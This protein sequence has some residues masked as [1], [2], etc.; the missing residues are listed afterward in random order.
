MNARLP[1]A[2]IELER[3]R[4]RQ[5]EESDANALFAIHS[6]LE[7]ARY[8]SKPAMTDRAQAEELVKR[9]RAG[10]EDG[11]SLQLGIERKE[12]GVLI[13]YCLLFHFDEENRRA[14]IGYSLGRPY[15]GRGY[16]HEALLALLE[17]AFGAL[18]LN[19]LEAD[20]DPRNAPSARSL[21]RL[22]FKKEGYLR[23]RWIVN[24]E[25]SD[26]ALYGLLHSEW[27]RA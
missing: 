8:Q 4:L 9:I 14:E 17:I 27:R 22:G 7:V 6:D 25:V 12:D 18:G 16:M 11:R 26:T 24:G 21:E 10:Y 19:R 20:I 1:T 13:G 2:P 15:W 3:V 23:E 5:I